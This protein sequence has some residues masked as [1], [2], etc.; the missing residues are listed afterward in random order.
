MPK[1]DAE[2]GGQNLQE[3]LLDTKERGGKNELEEKPVNK[4]K[5]DRRVAC[6]L[7]QR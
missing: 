1:G 6:E 7:N 5:S 3:A 4:L 2:V